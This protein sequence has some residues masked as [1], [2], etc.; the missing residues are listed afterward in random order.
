M[1]ESE[2]LMPGWRSGRR[3]VN[4]LWLH[5]VEAGPR[6]G[7]LLVL[8][9]G[10]PEFWWA[11]RHQIAPLAEAGFHVAAPDLRGY[12]LSDA[13]RGIGSYRLD[14]LVADVLALA[15]G[16]G[17]GRFDL[18]GHDWGGVIAWAT[19]A[20]H[21]DRI[22]R[23]V[24]L[25]APNPDLLGQ[26]LKH[27]TQALRSSYAA[28]FQLPLLPEALLGAF[29]FAGLRAL[30]RGS[31]RP[32][33]FRPGDLDRYAAA[34]GQPG[35]LGAMLNYYRALRQRR[36][37]PGARAHPARD[38]G[39]VGGKGRGAGTPCR[40]R[41]RGAVRRRAASGPARH[42]PLAASRGAGARHGRDPGLPEGAFVK[43]GRPRP[44]AR[45]HRGPTR[46]SPRM[47]RMWCVPTKAGSSF[48]TSAI[49]A[50]ASTPPGA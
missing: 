1:P 34:W 46:L 16:L 26:A 6:D 49:A 47:R 13:P 37:P 43:D 39:A 18:V 17:A 29:G 21:P 11:W 42:D 25:D 3:Q 33:S 32:D 48:S 41:R 12:N 15:D 7:P 24:V 45:S 10:F 23:L 4:G 22:G 35:R 20:R 5:V 40:P 27:P 19:A 30:M 50:I 2:L 9:H 8:L 28:F 38:A 36:R 14:L 31:A 44:G